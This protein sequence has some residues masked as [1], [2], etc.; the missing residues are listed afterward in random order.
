[1]IK[2][3]QEKQKVLFEQLNKIGIKANSLTDAFAVDTR[4]YLARRLQTIVFKKGL[5]NT[6][7]EARQKIV[8]RKISVDGKVINKPS[9][10]VPV[11][12]EDKITIKNKKKSAIKKE[13]S[14]E[15]PS[16]IEA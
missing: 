10:I 3:S 14:E 7:K 5:S 12:L 15:K 9:Y 1:M 11:E 13:A 4:A 16:E 2:S 6:I 8:H